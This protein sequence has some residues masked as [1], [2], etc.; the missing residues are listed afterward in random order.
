MVRDYWVNAQ[1][2]A[3]SRRAFHEDSLLGILAL[4]DRLLRG[5]HVERTQLSQY[6]LHSY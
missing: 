6:D 1:F 2:M 3:V 5:F 4:I